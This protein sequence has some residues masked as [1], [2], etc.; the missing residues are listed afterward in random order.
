MQSDATIDV[1]GLGSVTVGAA[2]DALTA[3]ALNLPEGETPLYM[4]PVGYPK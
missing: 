2:D 1:L 3:K 4:I